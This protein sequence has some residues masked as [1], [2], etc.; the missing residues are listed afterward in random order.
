MAGGAEGDATFE[1][2]PS[3][4]IGAVVFGIVAVSLVIEKLLHRLGHASF[5]SFSLINSLCLLI[6][7]FKANNYY[8]LQPKHLWLQYLLDKDKIPLH[9][10][11]QKIKEG[12]KLKLYLIRYHEIGNEKLTLTNYKYCTTSYWLFNSLLLLLLL[13]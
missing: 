10:A 13:L 8:N 4:I 1:S 5:I 2:T 3:W 11:L 12:N 7:F 9:M 6:S